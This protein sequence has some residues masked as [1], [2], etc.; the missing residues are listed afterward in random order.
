MEEADGGQTKPDFRT[1][2]ATSKKEA[3]ETV[4]WLRLI[5]ATDATASASVIPLLDEAN[6]IASII[7]AIKRNADANANRGT[8]IGVSLIVSG[9]YWMLS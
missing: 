6:Q 8:V 2:V 4:Y 5:A 3:K 1:K 7:T 9:L